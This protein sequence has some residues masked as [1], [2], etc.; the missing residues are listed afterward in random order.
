MDIFINQGLDHL[1][2]RDQ[3]IKYLKKKN[4]LKKKC[5]QI[6]ITKNDRLAKSQGGRVK[7]IFPVRK[8]SPDSY[9]IPMSEILALLIENIIMVQQRFMLKNLRERYL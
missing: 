8:K 2:H 5:H 9:D 3:E 7:Y 6:L 4:S 1:D